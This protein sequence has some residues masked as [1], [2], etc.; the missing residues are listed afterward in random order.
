MEFTETTY[1]FIT[2]LYTGLSFS[3]RKKC[4]LY[5]EETTKGNKMFN[6]LGS[7]VAVSWIVLCVSYAGAYMTTTLIATKLAEWIDETV[8]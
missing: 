6:S 5:S 4:T 8:N 7:R 1:N 2:Q 3:V